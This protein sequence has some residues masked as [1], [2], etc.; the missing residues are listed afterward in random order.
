MARRPKPH[1]DAALDPPKRG[2]RDHSFE[3]I[4]YQ[5]PRCLR[6]RKTASEV[7]STGAQCVRDEAIALGKVM[8]R[9]W[10]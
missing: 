6:C 7:E 3:G 8:Q 9:V 4:W 2:P 10:R 1:R 5:E